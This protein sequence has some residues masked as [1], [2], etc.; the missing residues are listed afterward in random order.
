MNRRANHQNIRK[1]SKPHTR[2]DE[3][4]ASHGFATLP[5]VNPTHV[6]MNRTSENLPA[7]SAFVNPTH[8]GMNR[9][10]LDCDWQTG[11]KPHTR[12]DEPLSVI[13]TGFFPS[14]NPTHV[15]MNQ[16]LVLCYLN[17]YSKPHT[18]GD[19]PSNYLN[20]KYSMEVNP[21]HVGMNHYQ[22]SLFINIQT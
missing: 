16:S 2:G 12:G 7:S 11:S 8:V 19:E 21:A 22:R 15:G 20:Q 10:G 6:G 4:G 17:P 14:V 1:K 13:T 5:L 3:P 9:R 18:R